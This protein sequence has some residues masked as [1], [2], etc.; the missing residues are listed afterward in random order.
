MYS[1]GCPVFRLVGRFMLHSLNEPESVKICPSVKS[2]TSLR[3]TSRL[4]LV[5]ADGDIIVDDH[6][7]CRKFCGGKNF[8]C[9][10]R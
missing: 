2:A 6:R 9:A 4:K 1:G 7:S 8:Y 3:T 5:Y 10:G